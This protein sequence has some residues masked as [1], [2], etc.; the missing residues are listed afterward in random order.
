[1]AVHFMVK[2]LCKYLIYEHW[3]GTWTVHSIIELNGLR[4]E[5]PKLDSA[6]QIGF[7]FYVNGITATSNSYSNPS[8]W[9]THLIV[10][11]LQVS[12]ALCRQVLLYYLHIPLQLTSGQHLLWDGSKTHLEMVRATHQSTMSWTPHLSLRTEPHPHPPSLPMGLSCS[13]VVWIPQ[14]PPFPLDMSFLW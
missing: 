5:L 14:A 3:P 9:E 8:K 13:L 10:T 12:Y 11:V 4:C 2:T 7:H 6:P 1:M